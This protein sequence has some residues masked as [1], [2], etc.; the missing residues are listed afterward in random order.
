MHPTMYNGS[1]LVTVYLST[2]VPVLSE[3]LFYLFTLP[4]IKEG[5]V[6]VILLS[7]P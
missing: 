7:F 4:N 2:E 3:N 6:G 5:G 1:T